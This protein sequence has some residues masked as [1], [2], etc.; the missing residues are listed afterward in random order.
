M[1]KLKKD[2]K[3]APETDKKP[4]PAR[5]SQSI[6]AR[7]NALRRLAGM[8]LLAALVPIALGFSYLIALREPAVQ[9]RQ[10]ELV[11]SSLATQQA[12]NLHR[13][14]T[15]MKERI[16]GAAQSPLALSAIA[17]Q[18]KDDIDLVEQAMLDYF[19]EVISLRIIPIGDMGTADFEGGNQGLRNH[20]EVDLVRRTS[21][22]LQT[23]PEAYKF[24]NQWLTSMAARVTHPRIADR[25]AVIIVTIDN[26]Q[27]SKQLKSLDTSA[28][29]FA[30][31]QQYTSSIAGYQ[32]RE[33]R[34]G[35]TVHQFQRCRPHRCCGV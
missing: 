28:G 16:Q 23:E 7:G 24:E 27:I 35:T 2:K 18:A 20:I 26:G 19:P 4:A 17:S 3:A 22:E 14:F 10:I 12:T 5:N 8:A 6:S 15:R 25:L 1:L 11:A 34:A 33:I 13:L 29:K 30:L 21:V 32:R 31:E 9:S